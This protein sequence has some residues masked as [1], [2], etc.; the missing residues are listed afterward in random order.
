MNKIQLLSIAFMLI[1]MISS[2]NK[3]TEIQSIENPLPECPDSPN[4]ERTQQTFQMDSATVLNLADQTLRVMNAETVEWNEETKEIHAVFKIPVFGWRDDVHIAAKSMGEETILY[5]RSASR[6]GYSDLGV[7]KR[8]VNKF[9]R[10]FN[11]LNS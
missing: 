2:T 11:N 9:F 4:C 10:Q 7:N 5:I 3:T 1:A 8:R 6:E